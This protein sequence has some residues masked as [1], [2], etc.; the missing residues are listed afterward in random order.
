MPASRWVALVGGVALGA[1]LLVEFVPS[2]S[3]PSEVRA[4]EPALTLCVRVYGLGLDL[5]R[6]FLSVTPLRHEQPL[7][8]HQAELGSDGLFHVVGLADTD[9]RVELRAHAAPEHVLGRADFVRPGREPLLLVA[10]LAAFPSAARAP[11]ATP[12]E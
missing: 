10:D 3:A 7:V 5:G 11:G 9:H 4:G 2:A 1:A 6:C 12:A 8:V